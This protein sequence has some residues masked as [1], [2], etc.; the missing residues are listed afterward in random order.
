LVDQPRSGAP[1]AI[2][3]ALVQA[4]LAKT[5]HETAPDG[6]RWSGRRLAAALGMSQGTVL[7]IWR[8]FEL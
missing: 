8:A 6:V 3:D 2:A 7:R 1:R 4:V 5:L